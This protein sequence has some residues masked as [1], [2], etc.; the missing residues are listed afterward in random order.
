MYWFAVQLIHIHVLVCCTINSYT[1]TGLLYNEFIY[2]Y[3]FAV[4]LIHIH[5]LVC[6]TVNSY[7]CTGLLYN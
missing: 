5:V 6:C 2:M 1:C 7:T 3:W 4:Q